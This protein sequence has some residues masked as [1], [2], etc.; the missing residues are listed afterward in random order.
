MG[1]KITDYKMIIDGEFVD[2]KRE[3]KFKLSVLQIKLFLQQFLE[4]IRKMLI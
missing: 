2:S 4:V 3:Q 1:E